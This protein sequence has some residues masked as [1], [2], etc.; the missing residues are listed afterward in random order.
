LSIQANAKSTMR[1]AIADSPEQLRERIREAHRLLTPVG[2]TVSEFW[3]RGHDRGTYTLTPTLFRYAEPEVKERVLFDLYARHVGDLV[4][5]GPNSWARAAWM[6]HFGI[7]TRLLDWTTKWEIAAFFAVKFLTGKRPPGDPP[8]DNPCIFVL[9][10]TRLN[11][12]NGFQRVPRVPKAGEPDFDG[13]F[14]A[15][16][17]SPLNYPLAVAPIDSAL[18]SRLSAQH[19]CFTVHGSEPDPLERQVPECVFCIFLAE[20]LCDALR[21][22][23]DGTIPD[24]LALF[25]PVN[26]PDA[27]GIAQ[28][29]ASKADLRPVSYNQAL[30]KAIRERLKTLNEQRR[31]LVSQHPGTE[32]YSRQFGSCNL[33]QAYIARP[34]EAEQLVARISAGPPFVFVTG[35]AGIGKTNFIVENLL[36]HPELRNRPSLLFALKLCRPLSA[37]G[38]PSSADLLAPV[39][40]MMIGRT[41]AAWEQNVA[42]QMIREGEVVLALDGLDELARNQGQGA[43]KALVWELE[44]LLAGSTNAHIIIS[45]RDH[46]LTR[47]QETGALG[48]SDVA[49]PIRILKFNLHTIQAKLTQ[50]LNC[51]SPKLAALAETP[52]LYQMIRSAQE[53]LPRLLAASGNSTRLQEAWFRV[54]LKDDEQ[55]LGKLGWIAGEML[56]GRSDVLDVTPLATDLKTLIE[57]LSRPPFVLFIEEDKQ[58]TCSFS[59][60]SL[61]EFVL[62]WCV[63]RELQTGKFALLTSSPS[64]DYEGGEFHS[65]VADLVGPGCNLD[66]YI[67]QRLHE[68]LDAPND[69]C[70]AQWNN[71]VRNLF[72]ILGELMPDDK[73]LAAG[74]AN[75]ALRYLNPALAIGR[76]I[77]FKTRY[78]VARCLERIHPSA[79]RPYVYHTLTFHSS[80][81]EIPLDGNLVGGWAIRGFH[82]TKQEPRPVPPTVFVVPPTPP[83]LGQLEDKVPDALMHAIESLDTPELP[84]DA[85]FLGINCTHALIRWLPAKPDLKRIQRILLHRHASEPMKQNLFWALYRRF[86]SDILACFEGQGSFAGCGPLSWYDGK[87]C[88]SAEA[89]RVYQELVEA[90][91]KLQKKAPRGGLAVA[92]LR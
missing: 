31:A 77:S 74:A 79:P 40:E 35:K 82:L 44:S 67:I 76:Y 21:D 26:T 34:V 45:C 13:L 30:A 57:R 86:Q 12:L 64:F 72:E 88:A 36:Y 47:L 2:A 37:P 33:D 92:G 59:H 14:L 24:A 10:P 85:A 62:A 91:S 18:N 60:Q 38:L 43:V 51:E 81:N 49:E 4:G 1:T 3:Y 15:P 61:R 65:R 25:P 19:G 75:V 78:N 69:L 87:C 42:R 50:E 28:F 8:G 32:D 46:I 89:L 68:L 52:L 5:H 80:W 27:F 48:R 63:F 70:A 90:D 17:A 58:G 7:P 16:A 83:G 54:M 56:K 55:A 53:D 20:G 29:I 84:E 66:K 22:P 9:N 11:E 73:A 71:L 39:Y 23:V 41:G 6:Q